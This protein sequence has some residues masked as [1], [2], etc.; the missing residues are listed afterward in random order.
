M[1]VKIIIAIHKPYWIPADDVYFPLHVGKEG[2]QDI[3]FVG[4]NAGDHI[5]DRNGTFCELT[6]LYW[7][8][9]NLQA[10]YAGLVHYRRYFT[11]R[12]RYQ[13]VSKREEILSRPDWERILAES[14]AIAPAN[15]KIIAI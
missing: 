13:N 1:N 12:E 10:D 5:S 7:A 9:K 4:D 11:K 8:W 3:G 14:P 15:M 2:K 6:G